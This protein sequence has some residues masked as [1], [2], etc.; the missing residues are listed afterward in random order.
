MISTEYT[1][2]CLGYQ[3]NP[4]HGSDW[5]EVQ[6]YFSSHAKYNKRVTLESTSLA[7]NDAK[8]KE[9]LDEQ[10]KLIDTEY[11]CSL[12]H[13]EDYFDYGIATINAGG[14]YRYIKVV[15][16]KEYGTYEVTY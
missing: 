4:L 12:I 13:G 2:G 6:T 10:L 5:D 16:F 8:A 7:E 11:V 9:L 14:D 1:I 3:I 15:R